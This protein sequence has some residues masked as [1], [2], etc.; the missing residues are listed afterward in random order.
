MQ[1]SIEIKIAE[2]ETTMAPDRQAVLRLWAGGRHL[3]GV[4][5]GRRP[6]RRH[7]DGDTSRCHPRLRPRQRARAGLLRRRGGQG[8]RCRAAT[9]ARRDRDR[10]NLVGVL[11][12]EAA[13]A[14][15]ALIGHIEGLDHE[16]FFR[17]DLVA[18]TVED[19]WGEGT[20]DDLQA[21]DTPE[22]LYQ[23]ARSDGMAID[24]GADAIRD[25]IEMLR[26]E[27]EEEAA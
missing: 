14:E 24:G 4:R 11:T 21:D 23:V 27:R 26:K 18:L 17:D 20:L 19:W 7:T 2:I 25:H 9:A 8:I 22:I 13:A 3:V 12:P 1:E 5:G 15:E 16:H 6:G 10:A